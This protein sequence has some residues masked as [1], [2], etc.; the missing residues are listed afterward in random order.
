MSSPSTTFNST[1]LTTTAM[2][3]HTPDHA[4]SQLIR[5]P[6]DMLRHPAVDMRPHTAVLELQASVG[7]IPVPTPPAAFAAVFMFLLDVEART[8]GSRL[9]EQA[10]RLLEELYVFTICK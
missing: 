4:V 7:G 6:L 8:K 1:R 3:I 9:A 2:S 10:A 5:L